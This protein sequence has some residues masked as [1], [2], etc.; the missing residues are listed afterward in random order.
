MDSTSK[1][2]DDDLKAIATYLKDQPVEN[3]AEEVGDL[4]AGV[5][6][7]GNAIYADQCSACHGAD[8]SGVEGLFP[9]LKGSPLVQS[10]DPASALHVLLRGAPKCRDRSCADGA[11]DAGVWLDAQ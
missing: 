11:C 7:S 6:K 5:M 8:G 2:T 3:A 4:D 10:V 1:F 9:M